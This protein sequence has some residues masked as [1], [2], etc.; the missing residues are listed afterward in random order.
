[1]LFN[2]HSCVFLFVLLLSCF[3]ASPAGASSESELVGAMEILPR[4]Q[5]R[6]GEVLLSNLQ[7]FS[8]SLGGFAAPSIS[9]SKDSRRPFEVDGNTF[10]SFSAAADRACDNQKNK[11]ADAAN[12]GR[13]R[14]FSVGECDQQNERCKTAAKSAKDTNFATFSFADADNEYFCEG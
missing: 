5:A 13:N 7:P 3:A 8:G 6:P 4:Q 11:C 12:A 2:L 1:M 9:Q 14:A 10:N